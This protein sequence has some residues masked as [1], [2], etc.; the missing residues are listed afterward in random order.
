MS[1]DYSDFVSANARLVMLKEL[2]KQHGGILNETLLAKVLDVF[3]YRRSREWVRVQMRALE[4][5]GAIELSQAGTVLIA[6]L[7]RQG[8]DHVEGRIVLDG[9]DVPSE[10]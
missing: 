5:V 2:A 9:V 8:R 1:A 10:V 4:D 3:G 7:K 6:K